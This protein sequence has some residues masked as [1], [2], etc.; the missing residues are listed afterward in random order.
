MLQEIYHGLENNLDVGIVLTDF[1][2]AFDQVNHGIL[3]RK[4]HQFHI[5]GRLLRLL[6][7][8]LSGRLQRVRVNESLFPKMRVE[9]VVPEGSLVASL[10]ILIYIFDLPS[11]CENIIPL[12]FADD[13]KLLS[14]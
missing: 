7:T 11:C 4:I 6:H 8:Y 1:S 5:A 12:L 13:T 3:L 14:I 9:S 10:M 2:K